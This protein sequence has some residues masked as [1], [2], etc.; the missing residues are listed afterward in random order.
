MTTNT[1]ISPNEEAIITISDLRD[2]YF[3]DCLM[4]GEQ[5]SAIKAFDKYKVSRLRK[6]RKD[7][8]FQKE[9]FDL[10]VIEN[11]IDYNEFLNNLEIQES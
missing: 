6:V 7:A 3:E 10:Q 5:V 1:F 11:T 8:D 4:S 9:Y 2:D